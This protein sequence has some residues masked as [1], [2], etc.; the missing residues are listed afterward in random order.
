MLAAFLRRRIHL[1]KESLQWPQVHWDSTILAPKFTNLFGYAIRYT[2]QKIY[3]A[4]LSTFSQLSPGSFFFLC[5]CCCCC[6]D[7][8]ARPFHLVSL[9]YEQASCRQAREAHNP[10]RETGCPTWGKEVEQSRNK[11]A[12]LLG[13]LAPV[14]QYGT[15]TYG[16][17]PCQFRRENQIMK[18]REKE[19]GGKSV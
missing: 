3:P 12:A 11:H 4:I 9:E 14:I 15:T 17:P 5:C 6:I 18:R 2:L 13:S 8:P 1:S 16:P 19:R 10:Q 7:S